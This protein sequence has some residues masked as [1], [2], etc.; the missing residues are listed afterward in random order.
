MRPRPDL[1]AISARSRHLGD[2]LI[3]ADRRLSDRRVVPRRI[4]VG[5]GDRQRIVHLWELD[6]Q[7]EQ[8]VEHGLELVADDLLLCQIRGTLLL[9]WW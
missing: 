2:E 8:L 3:E 5:D 1:G 6:R 7:T 4:E 9:L